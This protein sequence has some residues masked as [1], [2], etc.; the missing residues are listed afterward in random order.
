METLEYYQNDL[1][2]L[3]KLYYTN[4]AEIDGLNR[5]QEQL[6]VFMQ[7]DKDAIHRLHHISHLQVLR[8]Y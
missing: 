3:E 4:K 7:D 5:R 6:Q 1:R 2:Q 8:E